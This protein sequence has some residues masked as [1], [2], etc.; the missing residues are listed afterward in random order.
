MNWFG[1]LRISRK[2][3][4]AF[5]GL[6]FLVA[7]LGG[8]ALK[9][10]KSIDA[11][12]NDLSD[13]WM[14]GIN[15]VRAIQYEL[16][17]Q[18]T[19][20]YQTIMASEP[21]EIERFV[22]RIGEFEKRV[23]ASLKQYASLISSPEER[24]TYE[25][26]DSSYKAF[27]TVR[28]SI[29]ELARKNEDAKALEAT[30][31]PARDIALK[32]AEQVDRLVAINE[33]G[34]DAS[35]ARIDEVVDEAFLI[36]GVL[37]VAVFALAVSFGL[38]LGN[39]IATPI[40]AM[41]DAM[42][43]LAGG[44]K[45]VEIPAHGRKDEVGA[46]ADAVE[47]FKQNAIEAERLA[48]EQEAARAERERRAAAIE[49]LTHD[50]DLK[51][52]QVLGVVT[53]ACTELDAT[54]QSLSASAEQT[55]RQATVVAAATEQA[56]A[57]VQTVATAAEE[58]SASIGEIGRQVETSSTVAR[59]AADEAERTNAIVQELAHS[60]ARIGEVVDLI[61]D[62]ANQTNLLAL[63]ATI[64][65]ARAGDAGKGFAV[66]A[67]EVKNL[68][69]QTARATEEIGQQ[70][71]AVQESTRNVVTA[72]AQIVERIRELSQINATIASAV[73]EQAAAATEI[74][75]NVQQAAAGTQ[76]VSSNIGG[77]SEAA[78]ET[79]A[80]S[81]QVLSASRS[82]SGEAEQLKGLVLDFLEGVRAA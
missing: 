62:I 41:T 22:N 2:L 15:V 25:A 44:D 47:V 17:A 70:I 33:K 67:G 9:E 60:S 10:I 59:S 49:S 38:A 39:G 28:G 24:Q 65:A 7:L 40:I 57:S 12:S 68:A 43:R 72:I 77:V 73:E 14:P 8:L 37:L 31:G 64:E 58:L 69:N 11:A 75:R 78:G 46:M 20:L 63:N 32:M 56:S 16:Q 18:R 74:A 6:S 1:N 51:V 61:T 4:V 19:V 5:S 26:L 36:V 71:S 29:L 42:R 52:S 3:L 34:A 80:A 55:T 27:S 76:E 81:S 79:G 82:L 66:V 35:K 21:Q 30:T 48:A 54:A 45:T 53:G 13:N 50:F 23:D